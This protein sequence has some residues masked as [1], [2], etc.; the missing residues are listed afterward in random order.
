MDHLDIVTGSSFADP[1]TARLAV[2]LSG[3]SL[4]DRFDC[5]PSSRGTTGH[6]RRAI[7]ST[8]LTTRNTRTNEE[9]T[10]RFEL[11]CSANR[12]GVVRVATIDD[13][14]TLLEIWFELFDEVIDSR[15]GFDQKDDL[16]W[17]FEFGAQF[18]DG[19]SSLDICA[20]K[21]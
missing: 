15:T 10:L 16:S 6:E 3:S 20:L 11:L 21:M 18:L 4:E 19:M 1:V 9:E 7:T 14:V 13:D 12:I 17:F 2:Y 8:F 5:G